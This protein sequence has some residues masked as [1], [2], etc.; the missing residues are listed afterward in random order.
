MVAASSYSVALFE[1]GLLTILI[2]FKK[3]KTNLD[4][5]TDNIYWMLSKLQ[6]VC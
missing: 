1:L 3:K 4:D 2:I 6:A 5:R